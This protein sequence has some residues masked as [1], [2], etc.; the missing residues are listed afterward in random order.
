M[1]QI[2]AHVINARFGN[3]TNE[4]TKENF[5]WAKLTIIEDESAIT[6]GFAGV[7][8]GE[9]KV[10]TDNDNKLIKSIHHLIA[11]GEIVL[12]A[13]LNLKCDMTIKGKDVALMVVGIES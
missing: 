10:C 8:T 3:M 5:D 13:N 7:K 11:H 4:E 1:T 6:N 12:P 9:L 2:T